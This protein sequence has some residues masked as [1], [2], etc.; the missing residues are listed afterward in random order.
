[1]PVGVLPDGLLPDELLPDE[2]LPDGDGVVVGVLVGAE[3][4]VLGVDVP[5][6]T[7]IVILEVVMTSNA[8]SWIQ[9]PWAL[10][11][12]RPV[13]PIPTVCGPTVKPD[14]V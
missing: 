2:V 9:D 8:S 12:L 5:P 4:P 1:M 14:T 7:G 13:G 10:A 3:L 11:F 6:D